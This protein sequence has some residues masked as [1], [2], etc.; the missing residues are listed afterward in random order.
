MYISF[1]YQ[2]IEDRSTADCYIDLSFGVSVQN[3][4]HS[5]CAD[6]TTASNVDEKTMEAMTQSM[7]AVHFDCLKCLTNEFSSMS[8]LVE[9]HER[10]KVEAITEAHCYRI[11]VSPS[12]SYLYGSSTKVYGENE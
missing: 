2:E 3:I 7:F 5:M 10:L 9:N 12:Q 6:L 1:V 4:V 8:K 11:Q